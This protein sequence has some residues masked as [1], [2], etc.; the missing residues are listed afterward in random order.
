M[1]HGKV[2]GFGQDAEAG[3]K[4]KP[5][6]EPCWGFCREDKSEQSIQVRAGWFE[7]RWW[8]LGCRDLQSF[9]AW[10]ELDL[11]QSTG[12]V[13]ESQIKEVVGEFG[14]GVG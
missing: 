5:S 8:T 1:P 2:P 4:G 10:P 9:D 14:L 7:Y 13:Y 12:L 6:P 11:E 3:M